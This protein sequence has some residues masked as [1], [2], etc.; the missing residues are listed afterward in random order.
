[1]GSRE[2][3]NIGRLLDNATDEKSLKNAL[4]RYKEIFHSYKSVIDQSNAGFNTAK[5]K[6]HQRIKE[7]KKIE[8][9]RL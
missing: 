3:V 6:A 9:E 7:I 2:F 5:S 1:M 4:N 8:E